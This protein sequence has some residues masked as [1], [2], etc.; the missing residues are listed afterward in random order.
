MTVWTDKLDGYV[1]D[2]FGI[3]WEVR[4]GQVVPET[5]DVVLKNGSVKVDAVFL[6]ADLAGSSHIAEV[7]PWETTAKII[8]AYLDISTRLI[9]AWGGHVRSFDGDRVMG[10]FMG[11]MKNTYATNC[12]REIFYTVENILSPKATKKFKSI[13]DNHIKIKNCV[14]VAAGSARAVRGG[15]RNNNDLIWIGKAPSLAAKLSDIRQYGHCVYI[16]KATYGALGDA[17]K[18]AGGKSI[19]T[20]KTI[21]FG[22][23]METVYSTNYVKTP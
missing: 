17:S 22:G 15:I 4:D 18:L 7:C 6:Y 21:S 3:T 5:D 12:A 9:R 8:R 13:R 1:D 20:E 14:G 16:T 10:V 2:T 11:E 19:W 23:G